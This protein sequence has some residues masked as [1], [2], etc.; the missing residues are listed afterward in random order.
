MRILVSGSLAYDRIMNFDGYFKDHILPEKIHMLNVSFYVENFQQNFGGTSGNICYNLSLLGEKPM[1]LAAYGKDFQDYKLWCKTNG[2]SLAQA[3]EIK[4]TPSSSAYIM[5]DQSDNQI[6]AFFAGTMK[7]ANGPVDS[8]YLGP[9]SMAIISPGNMADMRNY[10]GMY[11]KSKTPYIY[12]PGQ[13]IPVLSK[14]DLLKGIKGAK[15]VI[16]NDYE[17]FLIYKTC[18]LDKKEILKLVDTVVVTKGE[19]G[20]TILTKD[21]KYNIPPAKPKNTSDPT[22]AGDAYRAGFIKGMVMGL[23]WPKIGRL[24]AVTSVYTV[25]KYGTQ[26]HHFTWEHI[27]KRYY[28]NFKDKL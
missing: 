20:S 8:K 6:T 5:T 26:T 12:D 11:K 25:E 3:K 16:A 19:N 2:I 7:F 1:A 22:G 23:P 13:Q 27:Q 24:A 15:V 14:E 17:L 21:K 10:P 28:Q 9:K 4:S 18:Q